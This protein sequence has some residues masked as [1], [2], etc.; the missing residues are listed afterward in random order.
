MS[1]FTFDASV[2]PDWI[3]YN[4]H[5]RDAY[6]GLVFSMASDAFLAS[7]GVTDAYRAATGGT[8]YLLECHTFYLA[9]VKV[10]A[11]LRVD[12]RVLDVDAKRFLVHMTMLSEGRVRAVNERMELHVNQRPAPHAAPLPGDIR[13]NLEALTLPP[14]DTAALPQRARKMGFT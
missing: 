12:V 9:E 5:M 6:Y 14:G 1:V 4:G 10:D 2:K 3:D 11:A 7:V 13:A 8:V